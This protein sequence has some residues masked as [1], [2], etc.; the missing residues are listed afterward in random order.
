ML[1][2]AEA[3]QS[4]PHIYLSALAWLP[5]GAH[6]RVL[7]RFF[8]YL[9]II[10]NKQRAWDGTR[11]AKSAGTGVCGVAYSSDGS[12]IASGLEDGTNCIWNAYTCE[13]VGKTL[14]GLSDGVICMV[15]SSDNQCVSACQR[16][17]YWVGE[18]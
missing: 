1:A 17:E 4:A 5:D 12:L 16:F 8:R 7:A 6:T 14:S 2:Y 13:N 11:W 15:F 18:A 10:T 9:R 3:F